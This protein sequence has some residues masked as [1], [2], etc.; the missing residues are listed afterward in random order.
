VLCYADDA[1]LM[2]ENENDLQSLL[3]RFNMACQKQCES[4]RGKNNYRVIINEV[5]EAGHA[6][7]MKFLRL[8]CELSIF[9][10]VTVIF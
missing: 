7:V 8:L 3:F 9:V 1:I 6:H 10:A 2:T 4:S 5:V